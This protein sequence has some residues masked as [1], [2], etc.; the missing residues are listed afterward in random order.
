MFKS[1]VYVFSVVDEQVT[2]E[3][4]ANKQQAFCSHGLT[5]DHMSVVIWFV[6]KLSVSDAI[7]AFFCFFAMWVYLQE[8]DCRIEIIRQ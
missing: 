8:F 7:I 5:E 3:T 4:D 1:Y 6:L 2:M